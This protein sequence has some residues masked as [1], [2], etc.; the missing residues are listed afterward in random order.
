MAED[1]ARGAGSESSTNRL[2]MSMFQ[3]SF[4]HVCWTS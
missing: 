2:L 1:K 4:L 3:I